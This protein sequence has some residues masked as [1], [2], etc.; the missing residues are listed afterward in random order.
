MVRRTCAVVAIL[1]AACGKGGDPAGAPAAGAPAAGTSGSAAAPAQGQG[2]RCELLPFAVSTPVPEASAAAW[3]AIHGRP[4]LLVVGDSG[5][6]GAYGIIDPGTGATIETGRLPLSDDASDDLEGMSAIGDRFYG[7]T[8]SGWI[9]VWR[10][11]GNGFELV[12]QAYPLG[13]VERSETGG[14][15]PDGSAGGAGGSAPRGIAHPGSPVRL[16]AEVLDPEHR[17]LAQ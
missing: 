12:E 13:P 14:G 17:A 15:D 6:H 3:I 4:H 7:L 9:R 1:A 16:E 11:Q 5:N 8:S 2:M 10:R